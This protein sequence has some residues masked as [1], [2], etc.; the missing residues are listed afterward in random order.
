VTN[1]RPHSGKAV[2]INLDLENFF[3]SITFPRVRSVLQRLGYSPAAATIIALLCTECPR[4]PVRY[5]GQLYYVAIGPRALPQ[6]ACTSPA[7]SNQ[8]ARRLDRRLQGLAAKLGLTYTR[9]AD[10]LTFSGNDELNARVGYLL[11]RV[12]HIAA[13]EGFAVNPKKTRVLRRNQAQRVTGLVVN[14]RPGV[15]RREVRRLRAV[16]HHARREGLDY[17][18]REG[19]TNFVAW[20]QGKIAYVSMVRPEVGARLTAELQVLL[21]RR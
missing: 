12:R 3:P 9:Y 1:A 18:N 8:V 14:D 11:A 4:Q 17:Q 7:L 10:D 16:L 19:R 15:A 21:D 6:G 13:D 5:D 20:L 2:V